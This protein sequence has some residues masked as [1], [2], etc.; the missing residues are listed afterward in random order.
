VEEGY[1][2]IT[3]LHSDLTHTQRLAE[4]DAWNADGGFTPA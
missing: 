1:V 4:L 2:S 3:P